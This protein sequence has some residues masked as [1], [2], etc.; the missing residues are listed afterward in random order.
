MSSWTKL[1]GDPILSKWI[2]VMLALS[3]SLNG[4]LL[5]GLAAGLGFNGA[6]DAF[7]KKGGVRF[8]GDN[9]ETEAEKKQ[10]TADVERASVTSTRSVPVSTFTLED[11]DRK[12]KAQLAVVPPPASTPP[13]PPPTHRE[14]S[15]TPARSLADCIDVFESKQRPAIENLALLNDEEVILLTQCG[16]IAPYALEKVL[17]PKALE[18]AVK[19]RRAIICKC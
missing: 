15:T 5:K 1:V 9:N 14:S 10:P 4:Y 16:K 8:E 17:G 2:V 12:L 11:V 6:F 7:P 3:I 19:I 13:S 18:R